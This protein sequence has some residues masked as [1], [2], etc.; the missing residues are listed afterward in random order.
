MAKLK[1]AFEKDGTVT[2]ANASGINDG[3]AAVVLMT[4]RCQ[5]A[6]RGATVLARIASWARLRRRSEDHG[7]GPRSRPRAQGA[8]EGRLEASPTST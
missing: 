6:K 5:A 2:A 8:E 1:P 4:R 3:A 7:H